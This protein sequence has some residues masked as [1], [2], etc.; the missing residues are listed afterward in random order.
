VHLESSAQFANIASTSRSLNAWNARRTDSTFS[1][2]IA[3]AVSREALLDQADGSVTWT[4]WTLAIGSR[5]PVKRGRLTV[6]LLA[7]LVVI[8]AIAPA[9][10]GGGASKT[11]LRHPVYG[12]CS[13]TKATQIAKLNSAPRRVVRRM[14]RRAKRL[15]Y[16]S[17][18]E[19]FRAD[20]L[21]CVRYEVTH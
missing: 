9:G 18:R 6:R 2:D 13:T 4:V 12:S 5:L 1:S 14:E 17:I 11:E 15:H 16:V 19:M 10:C 20:Y 8:L 7:A 21:A 3:R